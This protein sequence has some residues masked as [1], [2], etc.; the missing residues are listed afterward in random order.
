MKLSFFT[1]LI[2][3]I[4]VA[5]IGFVVA[6]IVDLVELSFLP[7]LLQTL[8]L[9]SMFLV[10][11]GV[12]MVTVIS[13]PPEL[14]RKSVPYL[15]RV[16][17]HTPIN[18]RSH[19]LEIEKIMRWQHVFM[20]EARKQRLQLAD[21]LEN[22]FEGYVLGLLNTGYSR[23]SVH[24]MAVA[25]A[26]RRYEDAAKVSGIY[27]SMARFAPAFGMLGTLIGLIHMLSNFDRIEN[28]AVG[29]SFALMTTFYGLLLANLLFSPIE[30][31]IETAAKEEYARNMM[32]LEGIMLIHDGNQPMYV[33]DVLNTTKTSYEIE[34]I[35]GNDLNDHMA[36]AS[37]S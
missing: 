18:S 16:F 24:Q 14:V 17:S 35:S 27:G 4:C 33:Y 34:E 2:T 22:T 25:K 10:L 31:K 32:V 5:I 7:E 13:Y 8:N 23:Q 19:S 11:A 12:F 28:L 15:F 26:M 6:Y 29:L 30:E 9:P 21:S 36:Q 20:Y 37:N 1:V 3:G